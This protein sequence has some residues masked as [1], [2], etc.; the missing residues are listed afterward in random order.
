MFRHQPV[1]STQS[2]I[3]LSCLALICPTKYFYFGFHHKS[4]FCA[5]VASFT[6]LII[7]LVS[8]IEDGK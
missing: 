8:K 4:A 7:S 5:R 6:Y 1:C 3:V 2:H